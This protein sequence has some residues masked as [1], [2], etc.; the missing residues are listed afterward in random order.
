MPN[1]KFQTIL[2]IIF[3]VA[4][5]FA[6]MVFAGYI[7]TPSSKQKVKGS[8]T[9]VVWGVVN[10]PQF[11]SYMNDLSNGIN[12]FKISYIPKNKDTYQSELIESFAD[13]N[14]PDLFFIDNDT[15]SRFESQIEPIP[16]SVFPQKLF[17]D[18]YP[19][20]FSLFL[21]QR[22]ITA[23][24]FLIDPLVLY[25]NKTLLTNE[26][27][28]NPPLYWDEFIPLTE[29]LTKKDPTGAFIQSTISFGRFENNIHAKDIISLLLLQV[30]NPIVSINDSNQYYSTLG[31]HQTT[32]GLSLPAVVTFFTDFASPDKFIYSWNKSLPEA[33]SSFLTERVVFYI[34]NSSELFKLQ[35][36]NPNLSL[37]VAEIPQPRNL[38]TK[39]T[40]AHLTGIAMSKYSTNKVTASLATQTIASQFHSGNIAKILSLPPV[41]AQ[42]LKAPSDPSLAY[43]SI[44]QISALRSMA[45]RDPNAIKTSEIFRELTQS[46][47]A[48]GADADGAYEKAQANMEFLLNTINTPPKSSTSSV[49]ITTP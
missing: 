12:D 44:L 27:I 28:V 49:P 24:P 36:R 19:G 47:L 11:L 37:S 40:Y 4:S 6:V 43:Q 29:K 42:D 2:L 48:G 15:I 31:T 30:G 1:K 8:G 16:Y 21:S 5:V 26:G 20:A 34:G 35:A 17:L 9:V 38:K 32:L 23:Y 46:I 18:S 33:S 22:G 3:G 7:P 25:Y 45:W 39:K 13:G 14:A 41:Y 10:D